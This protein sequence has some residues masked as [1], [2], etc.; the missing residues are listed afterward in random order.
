[1]DKNETFTFAP[2]LNIKHG[3]HDISFYTKV[4]GAIEL[5]RFTNDDDSIHVSELSI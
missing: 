3:I 5:R 1:M 2:Q 4:F